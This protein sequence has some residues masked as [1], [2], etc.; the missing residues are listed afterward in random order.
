MEDALIV[1]E[2]MAGAADVVDDFVAAAFDERLADARG[3]VVEH[4][5]PGDA[6]PFGFAAIADALERIK[7]AL[8][9]VDLIESRG[10]LGTIA[11]AAARMGG[12]ALEF[13]DAVGLFVDVGEQAASGLA[14]EA[15]RG[16]EGVVLLDFARPS[17]RVV[18][19]PILPAFDRREAGETAGRPVERQ[20]GRVKRRRFVC[21]V[22]KPSS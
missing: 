18:L 4:L 15:Y 9:V 1:N 19:G 16:D 5:V 2:F 21:H 7:D 11:A 6:L 14:V 10:P 20:R 17:C 12:V 22:Q 13:A 3:E 8:G